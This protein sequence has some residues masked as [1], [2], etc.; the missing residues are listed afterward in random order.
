[1]Q[2]DLTSGEDESAVLGGG[3]VCCAG[4]GEADYEAFGEGVGCEG[5]VGGR[6]R[7]TG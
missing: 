4:D 7:G 5:A 1:M 2:A 3:D 6:G